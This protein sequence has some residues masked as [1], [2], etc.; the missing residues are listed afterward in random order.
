MKKGHLE[1]G[2]Y[3]T[4]V[5]VEYVCSIRGE[6]V[7]AIKDSVQEK[8]EAGSEKIFALMGKVSLIWVG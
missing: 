6:K 2:G 5:A 4:W 7:R 8:K 3:E 1:G